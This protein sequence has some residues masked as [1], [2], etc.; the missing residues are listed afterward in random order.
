MHSNQYG[1][2]SVQGNDSI[3]VCSSHDKE[4][5]AVFLGYNYGYPDQLYYDERVAVNAVS[6]VPKQLQGRKGL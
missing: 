3:A 5:L 6:G 1:G 2:T 4:S